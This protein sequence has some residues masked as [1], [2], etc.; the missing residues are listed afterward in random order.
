M[1]NK[2]SITLALVAVLLVVVL[3]VMKN[4]DNSLLT[5]A[6]DAITDYSNRLDSAQANFANSINAFISVSNNL[7]ECE[8]TALTVSNELTAAQAMLATQSGQM[9][10][11]HRQLTAAD[12][13]QQTLAANLM[14]LTNQLL[15]LNQKIAQ[16]QTSLTQTNDSLVQLRKDY[17]LLQNRFQRD[18]AER[19]VVERRFNDLLEVQKQ[20]QR[21]LTRPAAEVSDASIYADL[22]VEVTSNGIAHV[23]APE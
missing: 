21:L 20:E 9:T 1:K 14:D 2:L 5:T 17:A 23:I 10:D 8:T 19:V 22:N 7:N 11:L 12:L 16:T 18:V 13:E 6:N 15:V 3:V 4:S